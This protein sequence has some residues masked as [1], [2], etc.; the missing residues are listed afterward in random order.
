[1][2]KLHKQKI[3]EN[4]LRLRETNSQEQRQIPWTQLS[5]PIA[6]QAIESDRRISKPRLI[7]TLYEKY[8]DDLYKTDDNIQYCPLCQVEKNTTEHLYSCSHQ[9]VVA[10]VNIANMMQ[11]RTPVP[12]ELGKCDSISAIE[13]TR[14][15]DTIIRTI[16]TDSRTRI[17]LFN[18]H[19]RMRLLQLFQIYLG[20]KTWCSF[21][22][23]FLGS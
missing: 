12:E 13:A 5:I 6:V 18:V 9:D 1:M 7:K 10:M 21:F 15:K 3:C 20:E 22:V 16:N 17:G 23:L 4:Y 2:R 14:L 8:D 19:N 11:Q